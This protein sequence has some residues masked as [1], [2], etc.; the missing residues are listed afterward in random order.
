MSSRVMGGPLLSVTDLRVYFE[1][2][3]GSL[4]RRQSTW[5][6]AVDGVSFGIYAGETVGL[7]GESGCGKSTLGRA[8]LRLVPPTGGTVRFD[9]EDL[10]QLGERSMRSMRRRLQMIFQDPTSSLNSRMTVGEIIREPLDVHEVGTAGGRTERVI[11]LLEV[12]GLNPNYARRYPHEFSGGQ[13]QRVGIAR[14]LALNPALVICDECISSLDVSVGAQ[15]LNLLGDLQQQLGLAYLFIAHDLAVVRHMSDRVAVM[16]LGKLMELT[17]RETLY[18][19]PVHPYTQAL[20][21]A[22]AIPD[23]DIEREREPT[24]LVGDVP[25]PSNPPSGCVFRTRCP[26]AVNACSE[27]IPEW[28]DVGTL[29]RQ[30]WVACHLVEPTAAWGRVKPSVNEP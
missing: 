18:K 13:R 6:R 19:E 10:M 4:L 7:V 11:E 12:V 24:L 16:Y 3:R 17:D 20:L 2:K 28:R 25:S 15:I 5:V 1:Q 21:S 23:P 8:I 9:G 27:S 22:V 14:A 30:H 26:I 29:D